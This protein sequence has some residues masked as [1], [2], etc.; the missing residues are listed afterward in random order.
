MGFLD[1]LFGKQR[2]KSTYT[3]TPHEINPTNKNQ[4][5]YYGSD[6]FTFYVDNL[7]RNFKEFSCIGESVKLWIPQDNP[8]KVYIYHRDGPGGCLG[9]VPSQYTDIIISTLIESSDYE[10][11]IEELTDNKCKIRC[12]LSSKE[13]TKNRKEKDKE[14]LR[15]EL[16]KPYKP[17]KG[18]FNVRIVSK[19]K[20]YTKVGEE[21]VI[22]FDDIDSYTQSKGDRNTCKWEIKFLNQK[23]DIVGILGNDKNNLQRILKLHFNSFLFDV[24]VLNIKKEERY[25]EKLIPID[26]YIIELVINPYKNNN[27]NSN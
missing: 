24:K 4:E 14:S 21:L 25:N 3:E 7:Q 1:W 26:E 11:R 6:G 15:T 22:K 13:E 8:D 17:K 10:S 12:K 2:E 9:I 5:N 19:K 23:G 16:T 27:T 20:N 18:P